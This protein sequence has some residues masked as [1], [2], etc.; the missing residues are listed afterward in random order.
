[1]KY[2]IRYTSF[3]SNYYYYSVKNK[4]YKHKRFKGYAL[5]KARILMS[6]YKL[7]FPELISSFSIMAKI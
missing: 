4:E 3:N 5:L 2:C 1:M 6:Q 7:E